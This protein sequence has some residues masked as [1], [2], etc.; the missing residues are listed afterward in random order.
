[1]EI[2]IDFRSANVS[3]LNS[4]IMFID[5]KTQTKIY[6]NLN[7]SVIHATLRACDLIPAFLDVIR[8]TAEYAQLIANN[9]LPS[10]VTDPCASDSDERWESEEVSYF[11]NETLWNILDIYAPEG[12]V[13][14]AHPGDGSDFG[15]WED[16]DY[17]Y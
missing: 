15:Y 8:D 5:E 10:V 6:A 9:A 14:G 3:H 16:Q 1:M 17:L 7:E 13:F 4:E 11:L 12:Y 2:V